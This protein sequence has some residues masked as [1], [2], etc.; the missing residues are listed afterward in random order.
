M[1][2]ADKNDRGVPEIWIG[3]RGFNC[4]HAAGP[5]ARL[6]ITVSRH[7]TE[8]EAYQEA[9]RLAPRGC[10]NGRELL[11]HNVSGAVAVETRLHDGCGRRTLI[12]DICGWRSCPPGSPLK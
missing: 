4:I 8:D 6:L 11:K 10:R 2:E 1:G 7:D 12:P 5:P 3:V 9:L